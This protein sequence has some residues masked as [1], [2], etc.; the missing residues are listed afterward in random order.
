MRIQSVT[1][2]TD[3]PETIMHWQELTNYQLYRYVSI[4]LVNGLTHMH[5]SVA[6]TS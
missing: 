3:C 2:A 5:A 6:I 4:Q 1:A